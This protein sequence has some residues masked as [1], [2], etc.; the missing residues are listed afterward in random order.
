M[1]KITF[2]DFEKN[3][4]KGTKRWLGWLPFCLMMLFSSTSFAQVNAYMFAQTSGT[5][6]SIA[7]DGV[8]VPGS[9]AD[10]VA[11]YDT[12]SWAVAL[13]FS[14]TFNGG[15]Y[16]EIFVN[17]NGG[18]TFGLAT[19][20]TAVISASTL[21]AGAVGVM[22]RDLW[23]VFVTSGV[24]TSGSNT[25]TNVSSFRAIAVGKLLRTGSGIPANT[26]ITAFNETA[27]TIT[28]SAASTSTSATAN[29][30]WGSGMVLTKTEGTAPNRVFTIQ[31]EGYND[32]GTTATTSNYLSFQL[33][34]TETLNTVE[35][36]Y[37]DYVSVSQISRTNQ[38]G[39]R[40]ATNADFNN[41]IGAVGNSWISTTSGVANNS[42][43]SRDNL[44]F[45]A[46]GLT[47]T[48]TPPTCLP[49]TDIAATNITV[50]SATLGWTSTGTAFDLQWGPQNFVLDTEGTTVSGATSPYA[51]SGL[52]SS[53]P[54]QFYV[55][56]NCG[57]TDGFSNW[58]GP[59]NFV[60]NCEAQTTFFENFD[61]SA[62]GS[63][64]PMPI[65]WSKVGTGFTYPTTGS[66]APN[67]PANRLYMFANG[68]AATPTEGFAITPELSN[69]QAETHRLKF[70]AYCSAANRT[71]EIGYFTNV[72][73]L[74]SFVTVE[75]ISLPG[76]VQASTVQFIVEPTSIPAGVSNLVFRNNAAL[77]STTIYID[78]VSWELIPA[79]ADVVV[80]QTVTFNSTTANI[81]WEAGG[82]ESA[83]EYV[84]AGASV[85]DPNTLVPVAV[86]N[87]PQALLTGLLPSTTYNL[88]VRSDCGNGALGNWPQSPYTF[89]TSCTPVA[90]FNEN[91]E[92]YTAVGTA[93]PL[94]DCWSRFGNTGSSSIST[95]SLN[96]LSPPNRLFLSASATTATNA[97]AVMP[98]VSNLQAETHRLKF[99]AYSTSTFRFL[100]VGYFDIE[101]A[102]NFIV[103]EAF[104]MPATAQSTAL[105][106]IFAPEFIADG[107]ES[108]A[109]RVNGPAFTGT[110]SI[111]IDDVVWEPIPS[112]ADILEIEIAN[113]T[114]TTADI[115]W[116]PGGSETAWRYVVAESTVTDPTTLTSLPVNNNP[117]ISL[118][119]LTPNT[120]YNLWIRSNCGAGS[121]GL[122]S[123]EQTFTTACAIVATFSENFDTTPTG[124][125][126]PL[127]TCWVRSGNGTTS[128][129]TGGVAPGS[130]PNRLYMF[131]NGTATIPTVSIAIMPPV[132]N[133]AAGTHR[134]KFS[135]YAS[136]TGRT[137]EVGYFGDAADLSSYVPLETFSLPGT[138][139]STA[140]IFNYIPTGVPDG[141]TTFAFRNAG[142]PSSTAAYIDNVSWEAIPL[143]PDINV[144][145][146][147]QPSAT[148]ASFSWTLGGSETAWDYV[149]SLSTE[150]DP[151]A[152]S[153]VTVSNNPTATIANLTPSTTYN[154]WVRSNCGSAALGSWSTVRTF[155]TACAPAITFSENFD[156]T[157]TGSANP[158]PAC[159]VRAGNGT[160]SVNTGGAAPGSAPNRLYMF[161]SGTATTP[162]VAIAIM[163]PLSNLAAGTH[164]LKFKAYASSLNKSVDIGYYSDASDL[165]TFVLL[166]SISLPGTAAATA[167]EFSFTPLGVPEEVTTLAFRNLG[168]P[169]STAMYIDDV[170]WE[171][172]PLCPDVN[173]PSFTGA[174][175]TTAGISWTAGG[176][177]TT[178]EYA[179]GLATDSDPLALTPV[180]V[181]GTPQV[182]IAGLLPATNYKVWVRSK[183]GTNF[184]TYSAPVAFLTACT[185]ITTLPWTEGFEGIT[186]V[187]TT[188]FPPCWLE[189]NGDWASAVADT[190]TTPNTGLKYIRNSW[191]ANNE[192]MWTPGFALTAGTSYDFSF[193]MQGD[194]GLGWDIDV[195]YN[196][197][198]NS[199]NATQLGVTVNPSGTGPITLQPY[200][201]VTNSFAPTA[202]GVYYFAI[203]VN[204]PSSAPWY[205]AFDDF[206]LDL[207][208]TCAPPSVLPATNVTS[209]TATV[210]WNAPLTAPLNGYEYF[211]TTDAALI[212]SAATVA[213]G[214]VAAGI[215]TLDL[216][217]LAVA[218]N[219]SVFIRSLCNTTETS[220]WSN[221]ISFATDC[222]VYDAPFLQDF[223][224]YL[225]NCWTTADAGTVETGPLNANPGIW[226]VDGFLNV[227]TT[228][229]V[230]VNL[231]AQNNIG[232]LITPQM[233]TTVG[234]D[235]TFSFNYGA[236]IWN[237]T[238]PTVM[239]SDDFI[240]V[241][242]STNNGVSWTEIQN[243]TAASNV[244]N[245]SQEYNYEFVATTS[246][247]K[248]ALIASD[249][250]INDAEDYDF[251][252]DDVSLEVVLSSPT[253]TQNMFIVYPNPV[254]ERLTIRYNENITSVVV[255]NLL[256]QQMLVKNINATEGQLDMSNLTSG[257]YLVRVSSGENVQIIKV[258]KE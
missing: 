153:P 36:I 20:T 233:S 204:Q 94:P 258:I 4:A 100:E 210:S 93:N 19:S 185:A 29:V 120:T 44:N 254:K 18:A 182:T 139:A 226:T 38:I 151:S 245:N 251:F 91:F 115:S 73:D 124:T 57:S 31:W 133:L 99:K 118:T 249:G 49:P 86:S 107:V 27:G 152:L 142:L 114:A 186:T 221:P 119:D 203:R 154:L 183:C 47:F 136:A 237:Q 150:T 217:G 144:I 248:F 37:G 214:T 22:N 69:L 158:L 211:V 112:C 66:T 39:L 72:S 143:C 213:T 246:A 161:A 189:Q 257:T 191:N 79:C 63:S 178:W 5:Y 45:P 108:I 212:P 255:Y 138:T 8:L 252:V 229:A 134:L 7:A 65:C 146:F 30:G 24:T 225:P 14:F 238:T 172:Q 168:L 125:A 56:Q 23:G 6:Q 77:G 196:T 222:A 75:V 169:T 51:L 135:A 17:S 123:S 141:T 126:N 50:S 64:A 121:L 198:P 80:F 208:P 184:G 145:T 28:M 239:G 90:I 187:S 85:T 194:G 176:T 76:N 200:S 127:P 235:Y 97:V 193:F 43:V 105:E 244:S 74:S 164:R 25:I 159:W 15:A 236:T 32:Y 192:F 160:T 48:W 2:A 180:E 54:Y 224:T 242:M 132:S 137:I 179:L 219:T 201:Q 81:T 156:T 195:F 131:A 96:P 215:T 232:W 71:M 197:T 163:P 70:K 46:S 130:P 53:T 113:T 140:A 117:F 21:Y 61:S 220:G 35:A 26:T 104:E 171:L 3:Q 227:G 102:T 78:D 103:L 98:P 128:V 16:S 58:A 109:F 207:T 181:I 234:N 148:G 253:I 106:F 241:V 218:S 165:N 247:I 10:A 147:A 188:D 167:L 116:T 129:N 34:L 205:V 111:Y 149:Y 59:F 41:R 11:T 87:N 170:V 110:T 95:G 122:W 162:T 88:W 13:P 67:S 202:T 230:K 1:K 42:T 243:I 101:D 240:K 9:G 256:G 166:Q 155:I 12:S 209:S 174:T 82:F 175:D 231:Y 206:S 55:R 52:N 84:L 177:E 199:T 62:T 173:I 228:G 157:I 89:A 60:T 190:R 83:W 92:G 216:T 33:K 250:T 68:T 223:T 40:G